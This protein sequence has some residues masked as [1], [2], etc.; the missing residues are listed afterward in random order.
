[1][2]ARDSQILDMYL[3][4]YSLAE[5][6]SVFGL[7]RQRVHQIIQ[8]HMEDPH[9]GVNKRRAY[10]DRVTQSFARII[11]GETTTAEEAKEIGVKTDS[12]RRAFVRKGL[13][14]PRKEHPLHGTRY[15]YAQGCRCDDCKRVVSEYQRSFRGREPAVHG[16]FSSYTNYA[17]RCDL[18][19]AAGS[20]A[21][22]E[23]AEKRKAIV[24]K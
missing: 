14:L 21:N 5:V 7:T 6:G 2:R 1:M 13:R 9:F 23:Y 20:K 24:N 11:S 12:L 22:K 18:C 17:C 4:G 19:K 10:G 16:T 8:P 3:E 15:R